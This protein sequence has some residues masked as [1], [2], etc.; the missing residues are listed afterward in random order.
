MNIRE[1]LNGIE[2]ID[3][4]NEKDLE[5][6]G[7]A[8][9]SKKVEEGFLFVAIKGYKTDGHKYLGQAVESGAIAALVQE[10]DENLKIPQFLV[11]DSRS[12][13]AF[14]AGN[15]YDHPSKKMKAIGVTATNG[16]TT[17]SFMINAMLENYKL[18]TGLVG[19]VV[20]KADDESIASD[21]TTPESLDLQGHMDYMIKKG[22]SHLTMEVSSSALELS[23][24]AGVDFDVVTFNNISREHI[25]LHGTFENYFKVKSSLVTEAKEGSFAILNLDSKESA[26]LADKTKASVVTFGIQNK[27]GNL[28]CKNLDISTGRAKFTVEVMKSFKAGQALYEK[29]M[30][31]PISL[32]VPGYHSVCNAMVTIAVGMVLNI[33]IDVIQS[34]FGIF[35]GV[36]RRFEF[37]YEDEFKIIDDHFANSGNI[38]VTLETLNFMDYKNL[39]LVYAIRGSRG[40]IVNK[41][42]SDAIVKWSK[43]LGFHR[44]IATKSQE[45]T[46]EKDIVTDE[47]VEVFETTMTANN[48]KYELHDELTSA[49]EEALKEAGKDD[50]ILLA[51][52][53]GMDYG[54]SLA[55]RLIHKNNPSID[56]EKLFAPLSERVCGIIED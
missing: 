51:G 5:I 56:K 17:T 3:T 18:K 13:L 49:I 15:L 52:C 46:T 9:N 27:E 4:L 38:D 10:F 47:E 24:V 26:S 28:Y 20:I 30:E 41:E 11:K 37:I 21:L 23:R 2:I 12:A 22:V 29:G 36:E 8:Y 14:A 48:I 53:Q 31:F 54:A 33:P 16:K 42:N 43:N 1:L 44:I 7:I 50:V 35:Q 25:D 40:P 19:T 45:F 32:A 55:L 6:R 39:I 34:S